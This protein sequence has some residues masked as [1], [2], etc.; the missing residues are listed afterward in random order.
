MNLLNRIKKAALQAF[1][2]LIGEEDEFPETCIEYDRLGRLVC[3]A[4][5]A[6]GIGWIR[7]DRYGNA[8]PACVPSQIF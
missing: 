4:L 5:Y 2:W 1:D 6:P 8:I 7:C 3:Q